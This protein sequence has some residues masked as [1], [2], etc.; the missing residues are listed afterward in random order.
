MLS[1]TEKSQSYSFQKNA[2][3]GSKIWIAAISNG[4]Q[5]AI[6]FHTRIY[7]EN[8][9]DGEIDE[10]SPSKLD[11]K[12]HKL[13]LLDTHHFQNTRGQRAEIMKRIIF[14]SSLSEFSDE[15][16]LTS[17]RGFNWNSFEKLL[18]DSSLLT[19]RLIEASDILGDENL[20][21]K[22]INNMR[23]VEIEEYT[24][25]TLPSRWNDI[26]DTIEIE[27]IIVPIPAGSERTAKMKAMNEMFEVIYSECNFNKDYE[28]DF[29]LCWEAVNTM[30]HARRKYLKKNLAEEQTSYELTSWKLKTACS[31]TPY[32]ILLDEIYTDEK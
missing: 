16:V 17:K 27:D 13:I 22:I 26:E 10:I 25:E 7:V 21:K 11:I 18:I 2:T 12:N 8:I 1:D 6:P 20:S 15:N 31:E 28:R 30:Q 4:K 32:Y 24:V 14:G 9:I 23:D 29:V 19:R 3:P 5:V